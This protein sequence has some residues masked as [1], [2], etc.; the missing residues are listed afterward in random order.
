MSL[1]PGMSKEQA[2]AVEKGDVAVVQQLVEETPS[3]FKS[4][5]SKG[6]ATTTTTKPSSAFDD[7]GDIDDE[8]DDGFFDNAENDFSTPASQADKARADQIQSA[9]SDKFAAYHKGKSRST[10]IK[11]GVAFFLPTYGFMIVREYVR[12]RREERYVQ[13]G[14]E[15]LKAQKA[16]YFNVTETKSDSD[17]EDALKD[18]KK[19]NATGTDEDDEDDEDDDDDSDDDDD[20]DDD[21]DEPEPPRRPPRKPLGDPPKGDGS[22][23]AAGGGGG[24][25]DG[26]PSEEDLEKLKRLYGKS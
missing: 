2:A 21:D 9:T 10:T 4:S 13:K 5:P 23:G 20:D 14:L 3:V 15:I 8:D 16:E 7:Y 6:A 26:K 1:R 11:V 19:K 12:R 17:I 18:L 22:G 24:A 25:G